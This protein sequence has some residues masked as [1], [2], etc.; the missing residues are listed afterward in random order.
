MA[1]FPSFTFLR[2][3][4]LLALCL[5]GIA[6]PTLAD[7]PGILTY[8][9]S[10]A[11]DGAP[12]TGTAFLKFS[13]G[14]ITGTTNAWTH[15]GSM[16]EPTN[17][18]ATPVNGGLFT[19][20][21]GDTN[22]PNMAAPIPSLAAWKLPLYLKI[23]VSTNNTDFQVLT[24]FTRLTAAPFALDALSVADG[25]ITANKLAPGTIT[26]S[27]TLT[28]T[29]YTLRL[30][31]SAGTNS[32][33]LSGLFSGVV[34][35]SA[36]QT[37]N[38]ANVFTNYGNYF[39]GTHNGNGA[40]LTN[41]WQL[42]GNNVASNQFIGST[43]NEALEFRVAGERVLRAGTT[44]S[45]SVDTGPAFGRPT[46]TGRTLIAGASN[47]HAGPTAV[48]A[49]MFGGGIFTPNIASAPEIHSNAVTG[50]FGTVSGGL[51]NV[52]G[53]LSTVSGGQDNTNDAS[54]AVIGGGRENVVTGTYGTIPGGYRNTAT[55]GSFAA[56]EFA[57]A[58][59]ANSFVWSDGASDFSTT[60]NG[61]FIIQAANGVGI[62]TAS[63]ATTLQVNGT[64]T[65]T[66]FA[67]NGSL[68]TGLSATNFSTLAASDGSPA[69]AV[70]VDANGNVGIGT[71]APG[72]ALHVN[73]A[74][75]ALSFTGNGSGLTNISRLSS[76]D[77]SRTNALVVDTN[78]SVGIGIDAP[79]SA[80]DVNGTVTATSFVGNGSGLTNIS[81][82]SAAD[83]SPAVALSVDNS[84]HVGIGTTSPGSDLTIGAG[85]GQTVLTINGKSIA[86]TGFNL[87][88]IGSEE[89]FVGMAES[90]AFTIRANSASN[91]FTLDNNTGNLGI[92]R[93]ATTNKF[94]VEGNASKTTAGSWLANSDKRIKQDV[95]TVTNAL[96]ILDHVRLVSFRYSDDY[97][98]AHPGIVDRTYHNVIAQEF[99]ETFPDYVKS[100][101]E[102]LPNGDEIL[103]V[104]T[105]PLTIYSAAAIQELKREK[106]GEIQ[107][108]KSENADLR[109]R[110]EAL[111]KLTLSLA[112]D[113][114]HQS[115]SSSN[116]ETPLASN[117]FD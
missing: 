114:K 74:I 86:Y 37:F 13:I 94:E 71:N 100:S 55:T 84:G 29:G 93:T 110:L 66:A 5:F 54:M 20:N 17:S 101:G 56:G 102:K 31:D 99:K 67:G 92:G 90:S 78:G 81:K 79:A 25:S 33:N 3:T 113:L 117:R 15:G 76:L 24:P 39:N 88:S 45:W 28:L 19:V 89:W 35:T 44:A 16:G 53:M 4:A 108:L 14:D 38:G 85:T 87:Q 22:V 97:R 64:V 96:A 112:S 77:G 52:A 103:Q 69:A 42:G 83:G 49:T 82:L 9:G 23:W 11:I 12:Y 7:V 27:S 47:N 1:C 32:V 62:N 18:I 50:A 51:G 58:I 10:L 65:A 26:G 107:Q 6:F 63:P 111:E 75:T 70:M 43:N 98:A 41:V 21:L 105:Y 40:G 2:S 46:Y 36:N 59:H 61:Q 109:K 48:G 60:T 116:N 95:S 34:Y 57:K 106:D 68:L 104:D 115:F 30:S 80:L 72:S 8:Q 73:G 91:V